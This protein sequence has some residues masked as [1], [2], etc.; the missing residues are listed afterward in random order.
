MLLASSLVNSGSVPSLSDDKLEI[1][2]PSSSTSAISDGG[3]INYFSDV[4]YETCILLTAGKHTRDLKRAPKFFQPSHASRVL[5]VSCSY[6]YVC[7]FCPSYD[8][9]T[10]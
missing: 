6:A 7:V 1:I 8:I 10:K 3:E 4:L 9:I 5:Q 2:S